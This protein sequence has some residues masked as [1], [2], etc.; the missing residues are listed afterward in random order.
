MG[1]QLTDILKGRII[2]LRETGLTINEITKKTQVPRS[3]VSKFLIRTKERGNTARKQGSGR[4]A[5]LNSTNL[6]TIK[7]IVCKTPRISSAKIANKLKNIAAPRTIRTAL[8][9]LSFYGRYA[10][11][12]PF[13]TSKNKTAR[14]NWAYKYLNYKKEHWEK[15]IW[16]DECRFKLFGSDGKVHVWRKPNTRLEEKNLSGTVKFGGGSIML[17]G[18]FYGKNLGKHVFVEE[19]LNTLGYI[20][21]LSTSLP[22]SVI[23]NLNLYLFQQDNAPCHKSIATMDY[24][25]QHKIKV[26]DWPAQSPDLNPIENVWSYM[27]IKLADYN[28]RNMNDLKNLI[29]QIWNEIPA[30]FFKKLIDGMHNRCLQVIKAKGGHINY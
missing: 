4:P 28:P 17:W 11:K 6:A 10:A 24:F 20:D 15:V 13:L 29:T 16:S 19:T 14:L 7:K 2:G 18:C 26:M 5:I 21:I 8:N 12:K 23:E 3:T 27:K 1:K 22:E 9:N 25:K 30:S